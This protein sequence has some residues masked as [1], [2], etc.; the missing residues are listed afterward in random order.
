MA[1]ASLIGFG[2]VVLAV[3]MLAS[4]LATGALVLLAQRLRTIGPLAER[5]AAT[6]ALTLPPL[7][8]VLVSATI[9][10]SSLLAYFAGQDHCLGHGHHLHL[11]PVHG[12]QWLSE[13]WAVAAMAFFGT[14]VLV[15]LGQAG[16][17]HGS[18]QRATRRL[19]S[20][21]QPVPLFERTFIVPSDE[22]FAFTTGVF[23]PTVV[24]SRAAWDALDASQ[25]QA[26]LAH[27]HAHIR[28][29][30]LW[31]RA[32][33]GLIACFG[34][35]ILTQNAL[36]LWDIA[37]ERASDHEAARQVGKPS[38]VASAILLL[39][40]S[41]SSKQVPA[42]AVFAAACHV[43]ERVHSLFDQPDSGN[44]A[45][46]KLLLVLMLCMS[47]VALGAALF[48]ESLHHLLETIL[49]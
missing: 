22:R 12:A 1:A 46:K 41:Q 10:T 29:G 7:I 8:G 26:V 38:I 40:R 28:H 17:G 32:A 24:I 42:M 31:K 18:A 43:S 16:W 36:K 13:P 21:G 4:L 48:A 39:A 15:R 35:P 23:T 47:A 49:G 37:S 27:E 44:P 45:A 20:V 34:A 2:L 14:F 25:R 6:L 5:R 3:S 11:C 19:R 30:D 33:L 9:A